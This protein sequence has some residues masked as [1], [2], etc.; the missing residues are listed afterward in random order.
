MGGTLS[1]DLSIDL[2]VAV[3]LPVSLAVSLAAS[4]VTGAAVVG[5]NSDEDDVVDADI[6]NREAVDKL[7]GKLLCGSQNGYLKAVC[8]NR[9]R[10]TKSDYNE[11]PILKQ[12]IHTSCVKPCVH[13]VSACT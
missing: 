3:S 5:D 13:W 12:I 8:C 6:E 2:F 1:V 11:A 9:R 7:I 10:T 4:V